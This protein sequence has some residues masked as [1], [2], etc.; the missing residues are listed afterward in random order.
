MKVVVYTCVTKG[1]DTLSVPITLTAGV[2]YLCFNDGSIS[3]PA[4]WIDIRISDDYAGKD[5][6]RYIKILPQLN[7]RLAQYDL[8]IY[9]DGA[10]EIVGDLTSLIN[11]VEMDS[12]QIFMYEHPVRNCAYVEARACV[13]TLKASVS[14]VSL[15]LARFRKEGVPEKFG[16]FEACIIIRKPSS[17]LARLSMVW[18]EAY[19]SG[20]KR[21]QIALTYSRWSTGISVQSLGPPDHRVGHHY[22]RL[23]TGHAKDLITRQFAW[24]VWR[25]FINVL[26]DIKLI[27]L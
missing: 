15:T 4:P 2:D 19:M 22:F 21:D 13:A 14:M 16:L 3:V 7:S 23:K 24:W 25:P 9:V 18:W 11:R 27:K 5:A 10:V 12:G 20:I 8:T 6:N 17:D 26:I 1:Y